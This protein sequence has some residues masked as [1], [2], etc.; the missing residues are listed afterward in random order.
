ML[1]RPQDFSFLTPWGLCALHHYEWGLE[2]IN[3]LNVALAT[4]GRLPSDAV[5]QL[6][7]ELRTLEVVPV[8]LRAAAKWP[9]QASA[10]WGVCVVPRPEASQC[11]ASWAHRLPAWLDFARRCGS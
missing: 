6:A 1:H 11:R 5:L 3:E 9:S 4:N 2:L 7:L 8:V 10:R